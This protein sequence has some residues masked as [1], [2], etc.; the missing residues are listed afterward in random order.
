[1][2]EALGSYAAKRQY[3]PGVLAQRLGIGARGWT[4][5][6]HAIVALWSA[7]VL[8]VLRLRHATFASACPDPA[9]QLLAWWSGDLED[10]EPTVTSALVVLDPAATRPRS[11]LLP[12]ERAMA[13][14]PRYRDYA[15]A[16]ARLRLQTAVSGTLRA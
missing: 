6:T 7:E 16:A 4:S 14:R 11:Q 5:V 9:T 1:M 13:A 10:V 12:M 15:E 8:Q 3:P 2:Q